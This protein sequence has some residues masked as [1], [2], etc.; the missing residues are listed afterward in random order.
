MRQVKGKKHEI[1]KKTDADESV[2]FFFCCCCLVY[3]R[4]FLGCL[5]IFLFVP[6]IIFVCLHQREEE[7]RWATALFLNVLIFKEEAK[8]R[9]LI[10]HKCLRSYLITRNG[11]KTYTVDYW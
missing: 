4:R 10:V 1:G 3:A 11:P 2:G 8:Q 9:N 7:K 5:Y 6:F